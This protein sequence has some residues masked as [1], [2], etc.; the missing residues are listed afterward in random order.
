[1]IIPNDNEKRAVEV[2]NLI[3]GHIETKLKSNKRTQE[4]KAVKAVLERIYG[5]LQPGQEVTS[6]Y[7]LYFLE[8]V[9]RY[10]SYCSNVT[11]I[12]DCRI[13][14]NPVITPNS[15]EIPP[16]ISHPLLGQ[17]P[18]VIDAKISKN[19]AFS[20]PYIATVDKLPRFMYQKN[21]DYASDQD[22]KAD[23]VHYHKAN[24]N[25]GGATQKSNVKS[26][27]F[28]NSVQQRDDYF[29]GQDDL[30]HEIEKTLFNQ[31]I[32]KIKQGSPI[33]D[34][35]EAVLKN[36]HYYRYNVGTSYGKPEDGKSKE[37]LQ[38]QH[39]GHAAELLSFTTDKMTF[40]LVI[41]PVHYQ[42][43]TGGLV[44]IAAKLAYD[45]QTSPAFSSYSYP[46]INIVLLS[47]NHYDHMCQKSIIEAFKGMN[48]LFVV[49]KGDGQTLKKWGFPHVV[50][51]ASWGETV[52][53]R[54][55]NQVNQDEILNI[56]GL[57][58]K[59]ASNRKY[60]LKDYF[61]SFYTGYMVWKEGARGVTLFTGDT[62]VLSDKHFEELEKFCL[63][64]DLTID[65]ACIAHGPDRPRS[66]MECTHQSTADALAMQARFNLINVKVL[67]A[68]KNDQSTTIT[69]AELNDSCA[70]AMG[71]HQGCY[72]LGLLNYSDA[73]STILRI[74]AFLKSAGNCPIDGINENTLNQNFYSTIMDNFERS[75]LL[76]MLQVYATLTIA[77]RDNERCLTTNE[78]AEL[79]INNLNLPQPGLVTSLNPGA[80]RPTFKYDLERLIVNRQPLGKVRDKAY[81]YY[82][83][84]IGHT[85]LTTVKN[86]TIEFNLDEQK[87][88]IQAILECYISS[89]KSKSKKEKARNA[90]N[91][92]L[93]S[94]VHFDTIEQLHQ[95]ITELYLSVKGETRYDETTRNEGKFITG[96]IMFFNLVGK[97]N[98]AFR[99]QFVQV[100]K[101]L[102][103]FPSHNDDYLN[104]LEDYQS[105][106]L[107][108]LNNDETK[109]P[110]ILMH[111]RFTNTTLFSGHRLSQLEEFA[112][113]VMH[114][115]GKS[116]LYNYEDNNIVND[117][118]NIINDEDS[119]IIDEKVNISNNHTD[120]LRKL[121]ESNGLPAP[122]SERNVYF[123]E[124]ENLFN[125]D[126]KRLSEWLNEYLAFLEHFE[127]HPERIENKENKENKEI[128]SLI[129][130]YQEENKNGLH[131]NPPGHKGKMPLMFRK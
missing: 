93:G 32:N 120:S 3:H 12:E 130:K 131:Q 87:S 126:D 65:A 82:V 108:K 121:L 110:L 86:N 66:K 44:E 53:V 38:I 99:R 69:L 55:R 19:G 100:H 114:L 95:A 80:S 128:F 24:G 1:M 63:D 109:N 119:I 90:L 62:A 5:E 118:N 78:V 39:I 36:G 14:G 31:A 91:T 35:E 50:E 15:Y 101:E 20:D 28:H 54:L 97:D 42:S 56:Q 74:L 70:Y 102:T 17:A 72:R 123:N 105:D 7:D 81:E 85:Y 58:A 21:E 40:N 83:K 117:E 125:S 33:T 122:K 73:E 94:I 96:L 4:I 16:V 13:D 30:W 45:R 29:R 76:Q 61:R 27:I 48:V 59:H 46:G 10:N 57:P 112:W 26:S 79:I 103:T 49:P 111:R 37:N 77:D 22:Y 23:I 6:Y 89:K 113:I 52:Q 127:A 2:A 60:N 9:S 68:R 88:L 47:H 92:F 106:L 41:D 43:G 129:M 64:N 8:Q 107:A 34:V 25:I 71:Y 84:S 104:Q 67:K 51:L 11:S 115:S 98:A 124:R 116:P 18:C 75:G